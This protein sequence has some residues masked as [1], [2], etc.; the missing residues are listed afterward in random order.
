MSVTEGGSEIRCARSIGLDVPRTVGA[1]CRHGRELIAGPAFAR[2]ADV[3]RMGR[4]G[5]LAERI[6]WPEGGYKRSPNSVKATAVAASS[7]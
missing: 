2:V 6:V 7:H 5:E 3:V 1:L 4:D